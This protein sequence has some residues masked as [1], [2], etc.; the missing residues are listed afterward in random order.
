MTDVQQGF[1]LVVAATKNGLGIGKDGTLPWKLPGDMAYFKELTSRTRDSAK[2]NAVIMGRKTWESIPTKFR[3]LKG[4]IN[5][6][7]SRSQTA[8]GLDAGDVA[9]SEND[10]S[11][12]NANAP[13]PTAGHKVQGMQDVYLCSSLE[14]ASELLGSPELQGR[15]ENTFVIGGGQVSGGWE[16]TMEHAACMHVW[17]SC[18]GQEELVARLPASAAQI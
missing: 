17:C 4:R 3:P 8:A 6:V 5:I 2:Q 16:G 12:A 15:V 1:Q 10:S 11:L 9:N 14:A 7:L 18:G 13:R